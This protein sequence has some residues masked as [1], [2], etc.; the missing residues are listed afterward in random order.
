[1]MHMVH[2]SAIIIPIIIPLNVGVLHVL[3]L[4]VV[5]D[6]VFHVS[7]TDAEYYVDAVLELAL[8]EDL[9]LVEHFEVTAEG[10]QAVAA[11]LM[12]GADAAAADLVAEFGQADVL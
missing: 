9:V 2:V 11:G 12:L 1:M 7:D 3:S 6:H 5:P 8:A 4:L 10:E